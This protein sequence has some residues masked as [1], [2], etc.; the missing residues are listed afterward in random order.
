MSI[1]SG[2][3]QISLAQIV[4]KVNPK[5]ILIIAISIMMLRTKPSVI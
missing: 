2:D 4:G 5:T 3:I 1:R